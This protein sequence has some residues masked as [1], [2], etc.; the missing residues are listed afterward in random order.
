MADNSGNN[1]HTQTAVVDVTLVIWRN[2]FK[3]QKQNI[4]ISLILTKFV[5][6]KFIL[7]ERI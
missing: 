7:P 6:I 5:S 1:Y 2:E 3:V 4:I